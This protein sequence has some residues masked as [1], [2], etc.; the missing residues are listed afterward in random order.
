MIKVYEI[1]KKGGVLQDLQGMDFHEL[2]SIAYRGSSLA[3]SWK[4]L[5]LEVD[6]GGGHYPLLNFSTDP[7]NL[8]T[9]GVLPGALQHHLIVKMLQDDGE[10]LP[11]TVRGKEAKVFHA[12]RFVNG[13]D[14]K[15]TQ[16][17]PLELREGRRVTNHPV[18]RASALVD[19]RF[20]RIREYPVAVYLAEPDSGGFKA[21]YDELKL[22]GLDFREMPVTQDL[23]ASTVLPSM[24][25]EPPSS[26]N[27][28]V[29]KA[30][31]PPAEKWV[32]V[33]VV[34]GLD[35]QTWPMMD[36]AVSRIRTILEK[37]G[38]G[39]AENATG[40]W[41]QVPLTI[42]QNPAEVEDSHPG[43]HTQ[44]YYLLLAD[45]LSTVY[46]DGPGNEAAARVTAAL[47]ATAAEVLD[48]QFGEV[49]QF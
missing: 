48:G 21:V 16:F 17:R 22:S 40:H 34:S 6:D 1:W 36:L 19:T 49:E 3:P 2:G 42:A 12:L 39:A 7:L 8:G 41:I 10:L 18:F 26:K 13:L 20:F 27:L 47:R 35:Y 25:P 5:D 45:R 33:N 43:V 30:G 44:E 28:S 15:R 46:W 23:P 11:I 29:S 38:V 14:D 32:S 37:V 4:T 31:Q 24:I 9:F